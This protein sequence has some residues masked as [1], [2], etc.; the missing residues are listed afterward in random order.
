MTVQAQN[1]ITA[2][3]AACLTAADQCLIFASPCVLQQPCI[4]AMPCGGTLG[5]YYQPILSVAAAR[6]K[7]LSVRHQ[8]L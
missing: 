8:V 5:T 3:A 1:Q 2:F 7:Q 6:V 4:T